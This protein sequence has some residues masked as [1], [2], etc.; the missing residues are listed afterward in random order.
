M[1]H[2]PQDR[3]IPAGTATHPA[4]LGSGVQL[5]VISTEPGTGPSARDGNQDHALKTGI[6]AGAATQSRQPRCRPPP[7]STQSTKWGMS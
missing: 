3:Q 1:D 7:L 6:G 4:T 2:A 5:P